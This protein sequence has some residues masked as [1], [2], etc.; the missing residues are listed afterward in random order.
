MCKPFIFETIKA[1]L[2]QDLGIDEFINRFV[3]DSSTQTLTRSTAQTLNSCIGSFLK[4]MSKTYTGNRDWCIETNQLK[5]QF[6]Y[7]ELLKL[8]ESWQNQK[9]KQLLEK[10]LSRG[11]TPLTKIPLD[12]S[13]C[14]SICIFDTFV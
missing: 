12:V 13:S 3:V 14:L 7:H 5:I 10:C 2:C 4:V 6:V 1:L 8:S 11:S 9:V